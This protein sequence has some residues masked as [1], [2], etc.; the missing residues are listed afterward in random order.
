MNS[1]LAV[2]PNALA[3]YFL[4]I[5]EGKS[6][7]EIGRLQDCQASTVLRR[8][9]RCEDLREHPEWDA[10]F[11]ALENH[12]EDTRQSLSA[13]LSRETVLAALKLNAA[14]L[15]KEFSPQLQLLQQ[16]DSL[17][18]IGDMPGG[19]VTV[20]G[21]VRGKMRRSVALAGLAF[22]WLVPVGVITGKVRQFK[23]TPSAIECTGRDFTATCSHPTKRSSS[24]QAWRSSSLEVLHR[25]NPG[26][27]TAD[28]MRI[29][30]DFQMIYLGRQDV[31]GDVYSVVRQRLAPRLLT[32][33]E[34]VCGKSTG[35][36]AL[37]TM[38]KIPARSGK[39]VVALA[40]ETLDHTGA[41]T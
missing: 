28:H 4:N 6:M 34:E 29:A 25:Q 13:H 16:A 14:H 19:A 41:L 12:Q 36:E 32:A 27:I 3:A 24:A 5:L 39:A 40:L 21:E 8:I 35:L 33:L 18:L 30:R 7:R 15:A 31:T 11:T 10:L 9:R 37:E 20:A 23:P 2:S 17:L 1:S 26:L 22:G 38:L